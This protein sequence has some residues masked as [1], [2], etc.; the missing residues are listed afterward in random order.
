M[1]LPHTTTPSWALDLSTLDGE[2]WLEFSLLHLPCARH[3]PGALHGAFYDMF[4]QACDIGAAAVSRQTSAEAC[5]APQV[6]PLVLVRL[7]LWIPVRF[8]I[9]MKAQRSGRGGR[10]VNQSLRELV[11][12]RLAFAPSKAG[13]DNW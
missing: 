7:L 1:P 5:L 11:A 3:V 13:S 9:D 10:T 12:P 6:L 8:N 4:A 2:D